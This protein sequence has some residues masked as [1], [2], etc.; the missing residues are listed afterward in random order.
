MVDPQ[1]STPLIAWFSLQEANTCH[2]FLH[3]RFRHN[4]IDRGALHCS[5]KG[6]FCYWFHPLMDQ[7]L[8]VTMSKP[9]PKHGKERRTDDLITFAQK[10]KWSKSG[11]FASQIQVEQILSSRPVV[12]IH[13][14]RFENSVVGANSAN[15]IKYITCD[16][17]CSK[18]NICSTTVDHALESVS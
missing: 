14:W 8:M 7:N 3:H 10:S 12:C 18:N 2:Y 4:R 5:K 6:A 16:V 1:H 15:I 17:I 9:T 13:L 11:W